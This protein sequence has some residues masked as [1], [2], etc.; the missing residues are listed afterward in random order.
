VLESVLSDA[1]LDKGCTGMKNA[2][3]ILLCTGIQILTMTNQN[4]MDKNEIDDHLHSNEAVDPQTGLHEDTATPVKPNLETDQSTL[5]NDTNTVTI[6]NIKDASVT[7]LVEDDS[8]KNDN[9]NAR[10]SSTVNYIKPNNDILDIFFADITPKQ[11][12]NGIINVIQQNEKNHKDAKTIHLEGSNVESDSP[13]LRG[14][15]LNNTLGIELFNLTNNF[16]EDE[17][18]HTSIVMTD[19]NN[20]EVDYPNDDKYPTTSHDVIN[21]FDKAGNDKN[22]IAV[23]STNVLDKQDIFLTLLGGANT[24]SIESNSSTTLQIDN[25]ESLNNITS[26]DIL[27]LLEDDSLKE[28]V[29]IDS[30]NELDLNSIFLNLLGGSGIKEDVNKSKPTNQ[31][32]NKD[33][34][35]TANQN[36][37]GIL[38]L[39]QDSNFAKVNNS[40]AKNIVSLNDRNDVFN[41][42]LS[43]NDKENSQKVPNNEDKN[44]KNYKNSKNIKIPT[45][46]GVNDLSLLLLGEI[47]N[48]KMKIDP[49][50]IKE[51]KDDSEF[52][53]INTKYSEGTVNATK[54]MIENAIEAIHKKKKLD[55][56]VL[57]EENNIK[58][59]TPIESR[60]ELDLNAIFLNLLDGGSTV[61][62]NKGVN[63][64]QPANQE[65]DKDTKATT[66]QN[67]IGILFLLQDNNVSQVNHSKS[68]VSVNDRNDIF[69]ALLSGTSKENSQKVENR[70]D[71][72]GKNYKNSKN[73]KIPN[74]NG[75]NDF[76]LLL[77]GEIN[78]VKMKIDA[79]NIKEIRL[80]SEYEDTNTSGPDVTI[81]AS[82]VMAEH[83]NK[84][85][86]TTA[87]NELTLLGIVLGSSQTDITSNG[88]GYEED[89][90][91][92]Y[93]EG[94]G[95]YFDESSGEY[96]NIET[97][98]N[99]GSMDDEVLTEMDNVRERKIKNTNSFDNRGNELDGITIENILGATESTIKRNDTQ[100]GQFD[101]LSIILGDVLNTL[102]ATL[103]HKIK[104]DK[105]ILTGNKVK[106]MMLNKVKRKDK[107]VADTPN[108][109]EVRNIDVKKGISG[110][111]KPNTS[112]NN[113]L[114]SSLFNL[115]LLDS[116]LQTDKGLYDNTRTQDINKNAHRDYY[117]SSQAHGCEKCSALNLSNNDMTDNRNLNLLG[118]HK[119]DILVGSVEESANNTN[120]NSFYPYYPITSY[121]P[122][123]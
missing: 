15:V 74:R 88:D 27:V 81:N 104:H 98:I 95:N 52:D 64:S 2:S 43:G 108:I 59:N 77:L 40:I 120:K 50:Y 116:I 65:E 39:L 21:S 62:I 113:E 17:I 82:E 69:D 26:L 100:N 11:K 35:G 115:L 73:I 8:L 42:L 83:A 102:N 61:T 72:N 37:L 78:N 103:K 1:S 55:T 56:L 76:S 18:G 45:L 71:E 60:N 97:N 67:D 3:G 121:F 117:P 24:A 12:I 5:T 79:G 96:E 44:E 80:D 53:D 114:D 70:E 87:D 109:K 66:N 25:N 84:L 47:S 10:K 28:N 46:N 118:G 107:T 4:N 23:E 48:V 20:T 49:Q 41:A 68:N 63:K 14:L 111:K 90:S 75:I 99:I 29:P 30:S 123:K 33:T 93:E 89:K 92:S 86:N 58:E 13:S 110:I 32:E 106:V 94:S 38:V 19:I 105:I 6:D 22:E 16:L 122:R 31:E 34:E 7:V 36:D 57:S 54:V 51:I 85:E 119:H 9:D 112:K 101:I 91:L